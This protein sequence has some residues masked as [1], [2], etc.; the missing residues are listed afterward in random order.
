MLPQN[1]FSKT[2]WLNRVVIL[3][4]GTTQIVLVQTRYIGVTKTRCGDHG[5]GISESN[6]KNSMINVWTIY[7][8]PVQIYP[9]Q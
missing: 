3:F 5:V 4:R 2:I 8:L 9:R 6:K 1:A 7:A